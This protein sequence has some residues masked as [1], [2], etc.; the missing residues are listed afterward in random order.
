M[1]LFHNTA[2]LTCRCPRGA[3]PLGQSVTLRLLG[4]KDM[5]DAFLRLY[6]GMHGESRIPMQKTDD[7]VFECT[8]TPQSLGITGYRFTALD[9]A[10]HEHIYGAPLDDM[11]GEG[12]AD[13]ETLPF[14]ITVYQPW[15]PPFALVD[16]V[17]Y[18]IF[19]DRFC[20]SRVP[21]KGYP[22]SVLH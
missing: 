4:A 13:A 1:P 6:D 8:V 9:R 2:S 18:Q 21:E 16:G 10:G 5:T 17:M 12:V 20:R 7:A 19:P 11:G 3:L 22:D 15:S 14:R